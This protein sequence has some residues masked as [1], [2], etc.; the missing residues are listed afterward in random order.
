M[1]PRQHRDGDR[2]NGGEVIAHVDRRQDADHE[3][4]RRTSPSSRP[5]QRR[6]IAS[7]APPEDR[8]GARGGQAAPETRS[9]CCRY[10]GTDSSRTRSR[11]RRRRAP[12]WRSR[13]RCARIPSGRSRRSARNRRRPPVSPRRPPLRAP[14]PPASAS[15]AR[16]ATREEKPRS[17]AAPEPIANVLVCEMNAAAR[18]IVRMA[19]LPAAA[20]EPSARADQRER[21]D[22]ERL[23]EGVGQITRRHDAKAERD[24]VVQ[25][26]SDRPRQPVAP[27][28]A[29]P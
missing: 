1:M 2:G 6:A 16:R 10:R 4:E 9:R 27:D 20:L 25:R 29:S 11:A 14:L 28:T 5:C 12:R 18:V 19:R 8:H 22:R 26:D 7:A 17:I 13:R 3:E 23:R 15:R 24:Q 21:G